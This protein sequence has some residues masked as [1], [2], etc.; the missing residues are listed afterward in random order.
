[1]FLNIQYYVG[2]KRYPEL[3]L[4]IFRP[5]CWHRDALIDRKVCGALSS[6]DPWESL[7]EVF[8]YFGSGDPAYV[9][10]PLVCSGYKTHLTLGVGHVV[11]GNGKSETFRA[12]A[13]SGC[14]T[15]FGN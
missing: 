13:Y 9:L 15:V 1:M 4:S 5:G 10:T 3:A 2:C 8:S 12:G 7:S 11:R 14:P 6:E